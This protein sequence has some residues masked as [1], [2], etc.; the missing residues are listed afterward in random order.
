MSY[1]WEIRTL[2]PI[3]KWRNIQVFKLSWK[4]TFALETQFGYLLI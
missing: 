4:E 1:V 3:Y 2:I